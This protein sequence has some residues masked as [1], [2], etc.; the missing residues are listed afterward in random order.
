MNETANPVKLSFHDLKYTVQVHTTK[1]EQDMGM[2]KKKPFEVLKGVTGYAL[3]GQ[4]LYIMGSSGAGKTS[5]MNAI[6][7]RINV[8][9]GNKLEGQILLNDQA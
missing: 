5:L 6:S 2:G 9:A 7:A 8:T 3:P 1:R 4:T